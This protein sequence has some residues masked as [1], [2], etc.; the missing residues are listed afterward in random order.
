MAREGNEDHGRAVTAKGGG[1]TLRGNMELEGEVLRGRA[2]RTCTDSARCCLHACCRT[3]CTPA[4]IYGGC[5]GGPIPRPLDGRRGKSVSDSR[6]T[7]DLVRMVRATP[8]SKRSS[9][10][11]SYTTRLGSPVRSASSS[12]AIAWIDQTVSAT[13]RSLRELPR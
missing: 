13:A 2:R 4:T 7:V 6:P 5:L 9:P 12:V 10:A 1:S 3:S 8:P 11:E